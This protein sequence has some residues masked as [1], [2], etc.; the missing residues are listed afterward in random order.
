MEYINN[1]EF[2]TIIIKGELDHH[3]CKTLIQETDNLIKKINPKKVI[4]S[5]AGVTFCDSSGIAYILGRYRLLKSLGIPS[6]IGDISPCTEKIFKLATVDKY[7]K[8]NKK[9]EV[10]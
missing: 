6:E 4:F 7:I 2:L 8:I 9:E 3:T 1:N 10:R 5:F